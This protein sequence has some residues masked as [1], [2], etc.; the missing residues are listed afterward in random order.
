L[1]AGRFQLHDTSESGRE[2][3]GT[4]SGTFSLKMFA[5]AW[6]CG[7]SLLKWSW[8]IYLEKFN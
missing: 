8:K 2:L 4:A 1:E 3:R 5:D 6:G 7:K